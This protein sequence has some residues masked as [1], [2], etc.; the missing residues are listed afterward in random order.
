MLAGVRGCGAGLDYR[1]VSQ[2]ENV[3]GIA[4]ILKARIERDPDTLTNLRAALQTADYQASRDFLDKIYEE[5]DSA[6]GDR[7][8]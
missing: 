6:R 3:P 5:L 8:E 7:D 4:D 2:L 1:L